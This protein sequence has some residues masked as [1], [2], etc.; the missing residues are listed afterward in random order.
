M[1]NPLEAFSTRVVND[2][3][4][5]YAWLRKNSPVHHNTAQNEWIL[6]RFQDVYDALRNHKDFSS[7][8]LGGQGGPGFPLISDDPPRHTRLRSLVNRAFTPTVI[9]KLEPFVLSTC[10]EMLDAISSNETDI[11]HALTIPFPVIVIAK[12][13]GIADKDRE[14]FKLWSDA[15]TGLLDGAAREGQGQ[16]IMEMF[17][18]FAKEIEKRRSD[19]M[20][21]LIGAVANAEVE[22]ERLSDQEI[23]GF[24]LLLLVAGN[25]TTTNLLGNMLNVLAESPATWQRLRGEPGLAEMAVEETLRFDSPIQFIYR[26]AMRDIELHGERI[27]QG[28]RVV[29]GFAS[30]NR[31][32][33]NFDNPDEFSLDRDLKRHLAFGHGIHF[34]L[35][36]PLA[37]LEGRIALELMLARYDCIERTAPGERLPSHLLRGFHHLPIRLGR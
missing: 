12:M 15:L 22:G 27:P 24:C 2:P 25:E 26:K 4:P 36:A 16:V 18:Y 13:M 30:A 6:S 11:V 23:I 31:D 29:V 1:A 10:E 14:R 9:R 33:E 8:A 21:D 32:P 19:A 3:Y 28:A 37:R 7:T 5:T 35:G 34:C 17:P 20:D